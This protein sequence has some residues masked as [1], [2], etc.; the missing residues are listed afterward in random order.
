MALGICEGMVVRLLREDELAG[1]GWIPR[2]GG[3]GCVRYWDHPDCD[4]LLVAPM[5]GLVGVLGEDCT[6]TVGGRDGLTW[7]I[8]PQMVAEVRWGL[9]LTSN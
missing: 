6:L 5:L 3:D 4:T 9:G 1:K 2:D 8:L 7:A